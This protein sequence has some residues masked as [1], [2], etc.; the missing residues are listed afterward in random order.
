MKTNYRSF[1][2]SSYY[3]FRYADDHRFGILSLAS[4]GLLYQSHHRSEWR[5]YLVVLHLSILQNSCFQS[6]PMLR[7]S[8]LSMHSI[9]QDPCCQLRMLHLHNSNC[10][11]ANSIPLRAHYFHGYHSH[12]SHRM[13]SFLGPDKDF[14]DH[15]LGHDLECL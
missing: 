14:H 13:N 10:R 4:A 12:P 2:G 15:V 8:P 9:L 11:K 5:H 7:S 6:R 1:S 3:H